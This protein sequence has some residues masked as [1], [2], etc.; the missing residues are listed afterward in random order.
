MSHKR[1]WPQCDICGSPQPELFWCPTCGQF[2]DAL[3][4][5][6]LDEHEC[7]PQSKGKTTEELDFDEE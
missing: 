5:K 6:C 4:E 1:H 7:Q 3:C 2:G